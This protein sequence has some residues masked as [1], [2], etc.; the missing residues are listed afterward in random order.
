MASDFRRTRG[1]PWCATAG[2]GFD[3]SETV[4]PLVL[5]PSWFP[6]SPLLKAARTGLVPM[7]SSSEFNTCSPFSQVQAWITLC[8]PSA[9]P[10]STEGR[11]RP[12]NHWS[13]HFSEA[14]RCSSS[15]PS[16]PLALGP[17][18]QGGAVVSDHAAFHT[19]TSR[20]N[21]AFPSYRTAPRKA[22]WWYY[23]LSFS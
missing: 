21:L 22:G 14:C 17:V 20:V 4:L 23:N 5:N 6:Q 11:K 12:C 10:S 13:C 16:W 18:Y 9:T 3:H 1:N 8:A 7:A 15:W 2:W 19:P